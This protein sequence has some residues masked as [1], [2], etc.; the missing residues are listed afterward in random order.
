[1]ISKTKIIKL[2]IIGLLFT[3][4]GFVFA[5]DE[6]KTREFVYANKRNVKLYKDNKHKSRVLDR[7]DYGA[8]LTV[9]DHNRGD[10]GWI[11]VSIGNDYGYINSTD[12]YY[13][14]PYYYNDSYYNGNHHN[15]PNRGHRHNDNGRAEE[16]REAR[17]QIDHLRQQQHQLRPEFDYQNRQNHRNNHR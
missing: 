10:K 1:M 9:I 2:S 12:I 5:D 7:I 17:R 15:R 3:T 13:S 16:M 4:F 14:N 11:Y 8:Q 6:E